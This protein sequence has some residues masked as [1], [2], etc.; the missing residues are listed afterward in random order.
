MYGPQAGGQNLAR[1]KHARF[2]AIYE[3]MLTLPNG[4]ERDAL[5]REAKLISVAFMPYKI[6]VHRISTDL[7]HPWVVGFRRGSFWQDWWHMVDIDD[8]RRPAQ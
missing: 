2:D 5:Y 4:P 7:L 1:F 3:R 8:S 6:H